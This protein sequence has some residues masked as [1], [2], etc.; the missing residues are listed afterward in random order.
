MIET[1]D[2][3]TYCEMINKNDFVMIDFSAPWCPDCRLIEPM[4]DILAQ[5]FPQVKFY[6]VSFDSESTLKDE[7]NIRRIPTLICYKNGIE[8][9]ERLIEVRNIEHI[10][11]ALNA[12]IA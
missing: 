5:A 11:Q 8:V 10:K 12:L 3:T 6:K 2:S 4:L 7:L 1:I 9:G